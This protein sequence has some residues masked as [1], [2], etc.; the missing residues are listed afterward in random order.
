MALVVLGIL[1]AD[2]GGKAQNMPFTIS[3]LETIYYFDLD[4]WPEEVENIE[5]LDVCI[6]SF[7]EFDIYMEL[8]PDNVNEFQGAML[9]EDIAAIKKLEK[10]YYLYDLRIQADE[11]TYNIYKN[12]PHLTKNDIKELLNLPCTGTVIEGK[13]LDENGEFIENDRYVSSTYKEKDRQMIKNYNDF[14]KE[15]PLWENKL[16]VS[17]MMKTQEAKDKN[18]RVMEDQSGRYRILEGLTVIY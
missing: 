1:L 11:N 7:T 5:D 16:I 10:D 2:C 14:L 17:K 15:K 6:S 9:S 3:E 18:W 12:K 8:F 4:K 13:L